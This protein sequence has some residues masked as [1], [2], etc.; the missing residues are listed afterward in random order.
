MNAVPHLSP[1]LAHGGAMLWV[2][3][4]PLL[5]LALA[6]GVM[7]PVAFVL[8][9]YRFCRDAIRLGRERLP[10]LWMIA[11]AVFLSEVGY[12][13]AGRWGL[14]AGLPLLVFFG[15]GRRLPEPES[16]SST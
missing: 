7:L 16:E 15:L 2:F 6:V 3:L 9:V 8:F 1:I 4:W 5:L 13:L 14:L 10:W 12:Y 11:I